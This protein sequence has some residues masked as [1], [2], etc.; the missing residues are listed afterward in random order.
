MGGVAESFYPAETAEHIKPLILKKLPVRLAASLN[1]NR[2]PHET[3]PDTT[4]GLLQILIFDTLKVLDIT[5]VYARGLIVSIVELKLTSP[6]RNGNER[7]CL[8]ASIVEPL[9]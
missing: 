1:I 9:N 4:G 6:F 3:L 2:P 5:G 8:I 7:I